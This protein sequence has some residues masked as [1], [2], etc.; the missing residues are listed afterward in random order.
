MSGLYCKSPRKNRQNHE[1]NIPKKII[2]DLPTL[3]FHDMK[4]EPQVFLYA[5]GEM[6][7]NGQG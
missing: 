2:S 3:I 4:L 7:L 1:K 5:L 6:Q